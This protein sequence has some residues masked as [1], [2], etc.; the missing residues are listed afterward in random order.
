MRSLRELVKFRLRT[1]YREPDVIF[2]V[3]VFPL[4]ATVVFGF[5]FRPG[6]PA[7]VPVAVVAGGDPVLAQRTREALAASPGLRVRDGAD[8]DETARALALGEVAVV[9]VA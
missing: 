4:V 7:P 5:V 1:F 6:E 9:V 8:G 3:F 2:W